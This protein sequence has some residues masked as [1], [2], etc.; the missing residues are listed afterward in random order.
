MKTFSERKGLK[1]VQ[2]AL[3]TE[4]MTD[5]LRNSVKGNRI[6]PSLVTQISPP[7]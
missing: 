4:G 2:D 1:P 5:E 3:Q 7:G 6:F